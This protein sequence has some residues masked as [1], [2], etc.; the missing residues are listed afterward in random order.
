MKRLFCTL[1][2]AVMLLSVLAGCSE[3]AGNAAD[4]AKEKLTEKFQ[5]ILDEYKVEV[6]EVKTAAGKLN[7]DKAAVQF[8]CAALVKAN[9]DSLVQPCAK[10]MGKIFEEA[11]FQIQTGS[12][13]ESAYL[14]H[15]DITFDH[16]DFSDGSYYTLWVYN[17]VLEKTK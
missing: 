1:L 15:K 4:A 14:E 12:R 13:V 10:A 9:S 16:T 11:G 7:G 6:V 5:S 17:S 8:F 3:M 2:A